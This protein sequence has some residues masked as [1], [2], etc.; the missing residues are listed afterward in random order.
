MK[1]IGARAARS[2]AALAMLVLCTAASANPVVWTLNGVSFDDGGTASGNF[3]YDPDQHSF[4]NWSISVAGGNTANFPALTYSRANS[5]TGT[6]NGGNSQDTILFELSDGSNRQLRMT[7]AVAF[8]DAGGIVPLNLTTASNGSG[9]IECY[10]CGPVRL[11]T[12]GSLTGA[13]LAAP[14]S[15]VPA[16]SFAAM[17]MLIGAFLLLGLSRRQ[18][19]QRR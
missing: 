18:M 16:L 17:L 13:P 7:P 4:R 12:A 5:T 19:R 11:I 3:T 8:T 15:S 2:L 1:Q 6:T 10:N 14:A 9:G